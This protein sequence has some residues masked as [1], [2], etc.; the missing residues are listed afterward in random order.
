MLFEGGYA[1]LQPVEGGMANL[2]LL[3][4]RRV[5]EAAGKRWDRLIGRL[6][7]SSPHLGAR[8]A[9]ATPLLAK[10]L[11]ISQIPYGFVHR[12]S[13]E[14]PQGLFRLG[15]QMGVI[16]SFCGDGIAIAL[17]S[18]HLSAAMYHARGNVAPAYH[19]AMDGDVG[20]QIRLASAVYGASQAGMAQRALLAMFR[21][22]PGLV[23]ALAT[24]TRISAKRIGRG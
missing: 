24:W 20:S 17:H 15:D 5:F 21:L 1:G 7:R 14:E 23:T 16:P 9:G 13:L 22:F 6:T 12:P 8:L 19:R 3:V 11:S 2:C 4:Q 18:A 10:P